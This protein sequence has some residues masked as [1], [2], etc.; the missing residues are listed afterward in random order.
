MYGFIPK[1]KRLQQ[2]QAKGPQCLTALSMEHPLTAF[3]I[4]TAFSGIPVSSCSPP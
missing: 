3:K 2:K 1:G 4:M